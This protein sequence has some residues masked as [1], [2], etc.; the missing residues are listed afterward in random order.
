MAIKVIICLVL[1]YIF[2]CFQTGYFYGKLFKGID[3]RNYGSGNAGTTNTLRTLGKPAGYIVFLGDALKAVFAVWIVRYL[4]FPGLG[5]VTKILETVTALGVVLGH[6]YPFYMHFKGGKGI[7]AT[8]GF[9]FALDVRIA[10]IAAIV[11]AVVFFTT[12]YVSVGSLTITA[13]FP[14]LMLIFYPGQW[15]VFGLSLIFTALAWWRHRA[16]I[17]RLMNGTEN[18]FEKKKR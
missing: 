11:F 16:N 15:V 5:D 7:A 13:L 2:G 9:M 14:I 10:L 3:V 6:N 4:L 12:R 17:K 1:G 8:G 18:K